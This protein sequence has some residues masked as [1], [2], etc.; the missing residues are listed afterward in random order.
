MFKNL[1]LSESTYIL[2]TLQFL[3]LF[4]ILLFTNVGFLFHVPVSQYFLYSSIILSIGSVYFLSKDKYSFF[5]SILFLA[6]ILL[7][8]YFLSIY[9]F[10]VSWDGMS[11]HQETIVRLKNGWNPVY[12]KTDYIHA[13]WI[14]PYQKGIEIM[15]SVIYSVTN[16][17][18]SAK[19]L[20]FTLFFASFLIV[21]EALKVVSNSTFL[22][23]FWTVLTVLS[24][25]VL[26]QIFTLYIDFAYY[27]LTVSL[28]SCVVL[29]L[30][31]GEKKK[32]FLRFIPICVLL[33]S[34][35]FSTIPTF[36]II[37]G[38]LLIY[39]LTK[40]QKKHLKLFGFSYILIFFFLI[41]TTFNP[42]ITNLKSGKHIFHPLMGK[43]RIDIMKGNMPS[44]MWGK[45]KF[46]KFGYSL[47][48]E[49]D[50]SY[51]TKD[52][53]SGKFKPKIPLTL[54]D[55]E[56]EK[57][58]RPDVRL[59]GFGPMYSGIFI[60]TIAVL[61]MIPLLNY[62]KKFTFNEKEISNI[63]SI[64]LIIF[65]LLITILINP[66][67][68]W[69]RYTPQLW[70]IS[71]LTLIMIWNFKFKIFQFLKYLLIISIVIN[72][73]LITNFSISREL[74]ASKKIWKKLDE[75]KEDGATYKIQ[76]DYFYQLHLRLSENH[77][78]FK[79][80][81]I[82]GEHI[83]MPE[84]FGHFK[85]QENSKIERLDTLKTQQFLNKNDLSVS[86]FLK[87]NKNE[88]LIIS[89]KDDARKGLKEEDLKELKKLGLNLDKL[90]YRGSYIAV[91]SKGKVIKELLDNEKRVEIKNDG[92]LK[93]LGI[94][95]II[96]AGLNSGNTSIIRINGENLSLNKRGLN[97][98]LINKEDEIYLLNADT[99]KTNQLDSV[100]YKPIFK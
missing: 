92:E 58:I 76:E 22:R 14:E 37:S 25:I 40:S 57:M 44:Y 16:K 67:F 38:S 32:Y 73:Y 52:P 89:A 97:I 11:Y 45:N 64:Y 61:V 93:N 82:K 99:F 95:K 81:S 84:T 29:I 66:E 15:Q 12:E 36:I 90:E 24:P 91:I 59:S 42:F 70:L 100:I 47:F 85:L 51:S 28:I 68:W 39:L 53:E 77:I 20:N 74:S 60:F 21:F 46:I 98:V 8:L 55:G 27:L 7:I 50:N 48:S 23:L 17:I 3:M 6:F 86:E 88:T 54:R 1:K 72:L 31:S 80:D 79:R 5:F 87:K 34:I 10:D 41:I 30:N 75:W 56:F 26:V 35:K 63:K 43:E 83:I 69:A 62:Y 2:S 65:I 33:C 4:F 18:E 96:S 78:P 19:L 49:T 9:L 13:D 94:N 71:V